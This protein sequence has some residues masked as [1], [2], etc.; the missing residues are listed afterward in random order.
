MSN[1]RALITGASSGI[2]WEMAKLLASRGYELTLVARREARLRE[3]AAQLPTLCQVMAVDVSDEQACRALYASVRGESL[4]I[5]INNA[6]FGLF[7]SFAAADLDTELQM[8][9][10]NIRAVHILTKLALQDF[11]RYNRGYILNVASAAGYL[12]GPLMATYYATKNYVLRLTEAIREELRREHS[13]VKV[14]ALCPGPVETEF[15]RVAGVRFTL[16]GLPAS[17]VAQEAITG[18]FDGKAAVVPGFAM[19][20]MVFA[21]HFASDA[22][23][24]RITWH[25]QHKKNGKPSAAQPEAKSQ[26]TA[27]SKPTAIRKP[28]KTVAKAVKAA[29]T[30]NPSAA[31]AETARPAETTKITET[32]ETTETVVAS[33]EALQ[34]AETPIVPSKP[35]QEP[36]PSAASQSSQEPEPSQAPEPSAAPEPSQT[37]QTV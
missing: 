33:P 34:A 30:T 24:A 35:S 5:V 3:L 6:G 17:R 21:R 1:K 36:E 12:P 28:A 23:L 16:S 26:P 8:I 31:S 15:N 18:L 22:L 19:K 32:T 20:A 25:F 11:R 13:A 9:A 10:V 2:G 14:C 37:P 27:T 29:Q 7:G 4:H